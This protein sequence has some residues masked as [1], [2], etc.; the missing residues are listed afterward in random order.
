MPVITSAA[1][2]ITGRPSF[3]KMFQIPVS[4]TERAIAEFEIPQEW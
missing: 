4:A 3:M 2:A 1:S